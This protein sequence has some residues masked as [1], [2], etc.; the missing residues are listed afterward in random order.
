MARQ[1]DHNRLNAKIRGAEA[2]R[3]EEYAETRHKQWA[4]QWAKRG[5]IRATRRAQAEQVA[6][7][8]AAADVLLNRRTTTDP[9]PALMSEGYLERA[10]AVASREI[11]MSQRLASML[12]DLDDLDA[13]EA[14]SEGRQPP[15]TLPRS[16]P[17]T[18]MR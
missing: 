16:G 9:T 1:I 3:A 17:R 5:A 7:T 4:K 13:I 10:G 15:H 6:A 12:D 8:L 11:T 18:T 14:P 2:A